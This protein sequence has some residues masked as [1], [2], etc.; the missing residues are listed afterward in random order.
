[1]PSAEQ[2]GKTP[3]P[4]QRADVLRNQKKLL[5]AAAE[6]FAASGVDAPVREIAARAGV[7]MGT[8]YRHFPTR[9]D[10]VVAVFHHQVEELSQA[11]PHLL[12]T[13]GSP[14]EA[15]RQW[16]DLFADFLVTKHGLAGIPQHDSSS[17]TLHRC[18]LDRLL[19]VVEELLAAAAEAGETRADIQPYELLRG[20]GNLCITLDHDPRYRPRRLIGLLLDGLTSSAQS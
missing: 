1:V 15:L 19:P 5:A 2:T 20:I 10:L 11:G 8:L 4:S 13:A 9:A 6:A 16:I 14:L 18:F 3:P 17:A 7:G 12:A